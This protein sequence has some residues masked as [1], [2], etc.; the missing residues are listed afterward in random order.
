MKTKALIIALLLTG[1]SISAQITSAKIVFE[2]KTNLYKRWKFEPNFSRW[3]K[4][5]DKIKTDYFEAAP[6]SEVF[7]EKGA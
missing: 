3:V 6:L 1:I 7:R 2:R 5:E 4:E